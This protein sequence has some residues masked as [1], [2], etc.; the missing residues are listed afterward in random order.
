MKRTFTRNPHSKLARLLILVLAL[1]MLL[2]LFAGC[3][4]QDEENNDPV[5]PPGLVTDDS[6]KPSEDSPEDP[7]DETEPDDATLP[8]LEENFAV[9]TAD[10]VNVRSAPSAEATVI[11]QRFKGDIVE[12]EDQQT[13]YG[14]TWVKIVDSGWFCLDL[15]TLPGGFVEPTEPE[16]T[17]GD[18]EETTPEETQPQT[19]TGNG[20]KDSIGKGVI[21]AS[22]LNIRSKASTDGEIVGK[23]KTGDRVEILERSGGWGR[24]EKGWIS[25]DYVYMDGTA[26]KNPAKG[27]VLGDQLNIRSGPGTNY[28]GVGTLNAGTRV[29]ILEQFTIGGKKWGCIEKGWICLDYVYIDGTT[30]ENSGT[31]TV[32][33]TDQLN[34]RSGP[35]TNYAIAG[36]LKGGTKVTIL[37]QIKIGDTTWGCIDKGWI[38]MEFVDMD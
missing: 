13:F 28:A 18:P 2:S 12:I 15:A 31:G 10:Q 6:T 38:S 29:N 16:E 33:V 4:K 3:K 32:N 36:S 14:V 9:I 11:D 27:V 34:I 25:L 21:T 26:G 22:E 5:T 20:N 1:S 19:G 37:T 7:T 30:G 17:T 23:L 8:D 24:I 35:G